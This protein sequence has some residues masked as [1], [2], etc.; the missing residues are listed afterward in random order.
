MKRPPK[1]TSAF[2]IRVIVILTVLVGLVAVIAVNE[3]SFTEIVDDDIR[4]I[5]KLSSSVICSEIENSLAG[6]IAVGR[7]MAGDIFLEDWLIEEPAGGG[8]NQTEKLQRYLAKYSEK[9]GYDSTFLISEQSGIYYHQQGINKTMAPADEHDVWY[10][11]FVEG[12]KDYDLD[13]DVDEVTGELTIFVNCRMETEDGTL[14]GV[15]GVGIK[16]SRL[17]ALLKQYETDYDVKAF[18]MDSD[19]LVQVDSDAKH[20]ESTNFYDDP[21]ALTIRDR[22]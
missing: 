5:S 8:Q 13:V 20:I 7:T 6:P 17:Q 9:Y 22:V 15:A 11:R 21:K 2:F 18:L 3:K 19:G 14:L 1:V 4:N 10:Y 12:G 16:M